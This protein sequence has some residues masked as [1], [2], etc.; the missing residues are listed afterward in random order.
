[1]LIEKHPREQRIAV[2]S[3]AEFMQ[4]LELPARPVTVDVD[5]GVI[6]LPSVTVYLESE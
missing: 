2:M 5:W 4:R 3:L 6:D 1:M